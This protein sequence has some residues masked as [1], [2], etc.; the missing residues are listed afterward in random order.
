M[1]PFYQTW[2]AVTVTQVTRWEVSLSRIHL[3]RAV[4]HY[5][6][7]IEIKGALAC[8][9][10]LQTN[11]SR[12]GGAQSPGCSRWEAIRTKNDYYSNTALHDTR[13]K[14]MAQ[15]TPRLKRQTIILSASF[16]ERFDEWQK[17]WQPI[18]NPSEFKGTLLSLILGTSVYSFELPNSFL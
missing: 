10:F 14:W 1:S 7:A 16:W 6:S 12:V 5:H 9:Y 13:S 11:H 15:S 4:S 8:L 3:H 18:K 2:E 17:N